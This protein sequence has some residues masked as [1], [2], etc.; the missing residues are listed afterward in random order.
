M[1]EIKLFDYQKEG[2]LWLKS[3]NGLL[4]Y[5]MGLGKSATAITASDEIKAKKILVV[6]PAIVRSNWINE[7]SIFSKSNKAEVI[8]KVQNLKDVSVVSYDFA[9]S[10]IKELTKI[11]WD[12]LILDESHYLKNP[13]AKRTKAIIGTGGLIHSANRIWCLSGTPM[14]NN[15]AELWTMFFIFGVTKLKYSDFIKEYC[16]TNQ[17]PWGG[18]IITGNKKDKLKDIGQMLSKIMF[19]KTKEEVMIELPKIFY[20]DL[21]VPQVELTFEEL[22]KDTVLLNYFFPFDKSK[23]LFD[24]LKKDAEMLQHLDESQSFLTGNG[25]KILEGL[26][27]SV[28]TLRVYCGMQKAMRMSEIIY[29]ELEQNYYDKIVL[30]TVHRSA[31]YILLDKLI[32]YNPVAVYGGTVESERIRR[33]EKFQK[34]KK[35]RVMV[36]NIIAAGIGINLTAA[37]EVVMVETLWS[38]NPNA[39]AIMRCHRVGQKNNVNVRFVSLENSIDQKVVTALKRKIKDITD[40]FKFAKDN[41]EDLI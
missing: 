10:K 13:T 30:F 16:E 6:C 27:G 11:K 37:S 35:T 21:V 32:K 17:N 19:R 28:S 31:M 38:P 26:A 24:K 15:V 4:A 34:D 39:Q 41:K 5:D 9:M 8:Y 14:G 20:K 23:E 2:V 40:V 25:F 12:C 33:I 22:Q 18:I 7:F 3:R 29:E 36:C 1:G